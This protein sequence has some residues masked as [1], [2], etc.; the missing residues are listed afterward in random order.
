MRDPLHALAHYDKCAQL[1][2]GILIYSPTTKPSSSRLSRHNSNPSR[3]QVR[4]VAIGEE[5]SYDSGLNSSLSHL[6]TFSCRHEQP[7]RDL[8]TYRLGPV[9]SWKRFGFRSS[10][11]GSSSSSSSSSG[12]TATSLRF[13]RLLARAGRS[14]CQVS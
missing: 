3:L 9:R 1:R 7:T 5:I 14:L 13:V 6:R 11:S 8:Q 2:C 4:L 10:F 12:S